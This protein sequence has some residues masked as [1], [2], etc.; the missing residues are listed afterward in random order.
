MITLEI[1]SKRPCPFCSL[2]LELSANAVDEEPP[3]VFSGIHQSGAAN[4]WPHAAN[5]VLHLVV[6]EQVRDLS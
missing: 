6:W 4:L 1:H 5:D 2:H 3:A